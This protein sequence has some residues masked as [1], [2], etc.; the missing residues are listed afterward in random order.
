MIL[1]PL[2]VGSTIDVIADWLEFDIL[3]SNYGNTSVSDIAR[4]W[5]VLKNTEDTDF[6]NEETTADC[7]VE[8]LLVEIR[9][10]M[11]ILG[12]SYPFDFSST[13]ESLALKENLTDDC[14]I[15]LF[16][17]II[18]H[19]REGEVLTGRY[20]PPIN[21]Y[22]RDLFQICATLAASGAIGG[23]AYSFGFPRP[24][25]TKFLVALHEVY[26]AFGEGLAV[27]AIP[28]GAPPAV[29]DDGI[30]I[31]AWADRPDGMAGKI[32]MLG[33]VASGEDWPN[34]S[35]K[36]K[37]E[38]F[39]N[40]WFSNPRPASMPIPSMF[41]PFCIQCTSAGEAIKDRMLY[42]THNF[43]CFYYRHVIP[44]LARK[45]LKIAKDSRST[46]VQRA[47]EITKIIDW[48]NQQITDMK[49]AHVH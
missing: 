8:T 15:Y 48:V 6:E 44:P 11:R 10:R 28:Q 25:H 31:I 9:N 37:T 19:V 39:H 14:Y 45:G 36:G 33:Q 49:A 26:S 47:N 27:N 3:C 4:N 21:N 13:G 23:N 7:F 40:V 22:V 16:C 38:T 46:I 24:D 32:Y 2:P 42:L 5:D 35:V 17:L 29:K 20:T 12:E 18:S 1:S 34:K 41:M 30:D 43:G